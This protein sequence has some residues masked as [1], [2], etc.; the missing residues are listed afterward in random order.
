MDFSK[1]RHRIIFLKPLDKKLN[2]MK[3]NVPVWIPFNPNLNNSLS[4]G[5]NTDV[6]ITVDRT[7]N[8][9]LKS[10]GGQLYAHQLSVKEYAVWASVTPTTGR[11]YEEAQKLRGETTYKVITRYLPNITS[12][13]KIMFGLQVLDIISVLNINERNT[14]L[15]II[16]KEKDCNGKEY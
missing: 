1:L 15:Q 4:V 13:M 3:E 10:I 9:I 2:G 12:D 11:E 8:A 14:E 5:G 6:Y 7:G 16:A